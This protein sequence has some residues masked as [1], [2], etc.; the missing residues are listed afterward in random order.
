L[1]HDG[2]LDTEEEFRQPVFHI[3]VYKAYEGEVAE[4]AAN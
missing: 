2:K 3:T 4:Q 1:Q